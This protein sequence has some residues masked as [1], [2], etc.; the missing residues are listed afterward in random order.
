MSYFRAQLAIASVFF[1][2]AASDANAKTFWVRCTG[3]NPAS[4]LQTAEVLPVGDSVIYDDALPIAL[5]FSNEMQV[6]GNNCQPNSVLPA[7]PPK[8]P[9]GKTSAQPVPKSYAGC[10]NVKVTSSR[11]LEASESVTLLDFHAFRII[12]NAT[13]KAIV[14]LEVT[15]ADVG[16]GPVGSS[17][18]GYGPNAYDYA[19]NALFETRVNQFAA[20]AVSREL[21]KQAE[22]MHA[23][24]TGL[25]DRITSVSRDIF[26]GDVK[27]TS[28]RVTFP[29]GSYVVLEFSVDTP[30]TAEVKEIRDSE[31]RDIM[32]TQ[33]IS[34]FAGTFTFANGGENSLQNWLE[35]A[36]QLG[37]RVTNRGSGGAPGGA[38][39]CHSQIKP[40]G[41]VEIVCEQF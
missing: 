13:G 15:E 8:L 36:R 20:N 24:R 32:T 41:E 6:V 16:L 10:A 27:L 12:T 4:M 29:D 19:N 26:S 30:T 40:D 18:T 23:D 39:S 11:P 5:G 21:D 38:V 34:R 17:P 35:N 22:I 25:W 3:C 37:V 14:E 31:Q 9:A 1:T 28:I 7:N 2:L 33:T